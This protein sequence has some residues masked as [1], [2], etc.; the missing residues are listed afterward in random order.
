MSDLS[1]RT[2]PHKLQGDAHIIYQ[3]LEDICVGGYMDGDLYHAYWIRPLDRKAVKNHLRIELVSG[4][5]TLTLLPESAI[6]IWPEWETIA[7][8]QE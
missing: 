2:D 3:R 5:T 7:P 6:E 8:P 1:K 4:G